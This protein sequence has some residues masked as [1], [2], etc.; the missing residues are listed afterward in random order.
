MIC[1]AFST[2]NILD[3]SEKQI[4]VQN[5][6]SLNNNLINPI[7]KATVEATEESIVNA[8]INAK[9]MTGINNNKIYALPHDMLQEILKKYN[10]LNA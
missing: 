3:S 10:R 7:F 4:K 6:K 2:S 9:T 1:L 8:M 5:L